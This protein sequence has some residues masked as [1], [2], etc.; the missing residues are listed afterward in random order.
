[1]NTEDELYLVRKNEL[2]LR[3]DLQEYELKKRLYE[4]ILNQ[5]ANYPRSTH[6]ERFLFVDLQ[7][8]ITNYISRIAVIEIKLRDVKDEINFYESKLNES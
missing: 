6:Q 2:E 1:M 4:S 8:L 3:K 5:L 7:N